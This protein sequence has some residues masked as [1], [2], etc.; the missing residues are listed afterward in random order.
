MNPSDS[1]NINSEFSNSTQYSNQD[2]NFSSLP[3][4]SSSATGGLSRPR[5]AKARKHSNP[6]NLK[7]NEDIWAGSGSG[8]NPFRRDTSRVELGGSGSTE[9]DS[10]SGGNEAFLSVASGSNVGF[11]SSS[12]KGIIEGLKSLRFGAGTNLNVNENYKSGFVFASDGYKS[13][14][15]DESMQKL[16]INDKKKVVDG[17]SKLSTNARFESGASVGSS[18][19]RNVGSALSALLEKKLNIEEAGDAT[20]GGG[21]S[22]AKDIKKF[23]LKSSE[24]CGDILA[25]SSENA[26]PDRIKKL[27]I[28]DF[29][30]TY[31]V[32]NK[33][34]ESFGSRERTGG[35]VGGENESILPTEFVFGGGMQGTD[36]GG[37]QVPIDQ[38]KVDAQPI[39]VARPSH[40]F[41]SSS[42]AGGDAFKVP[43]T[44][45]LEK[46]D[47][48]SFT[49]KQDSAGSPF[50]E[51][52]TPNPKGYIFTGSNSKMEFSTKVKDSKV[53]KKRGKL[54][55]PFTVPLWQGQ[56]FVD[57]EG[58]SQEIPEASESYSPMDISPYQETLSDARNSR[59]TSVAS[60][61]S[62]T[63]DYQHQSMDSQ[64]DV[65]NDAIDEDLVVKTQQMDIN[66]EDMKYREAKE[67]NSEYGFY[68][69]TGAENYLE[70]SISGAETESFK[71]AN[72]EIDAIN[73]VMVTSGESEASSSANVDSD[74]RT[75][76]FSAVSSEDAVSSGFTFAASSIAQA[77]PK[78]H[79]K[80][81]ILDKVDN[82]S[83]NSCANSKG[84]YASSSLQ[85]TPFSRSSPLSPVR[86][87][88]ASSSAASHVAGDTG[89]LHRGQEINQASVSAS[90]AAQ[91]ACDRWRLRGNQAYTSGDLS[92]AEDCYTKGVDCVSKTETNTSCL[93]TVKMAAAID[94]SFLRVQVRAANCY[95]ALGEVEEAVQ[96]F[97]RCLQ[98]GIDVCVDRK[99]AVEASDGLQKA[100]KVSEC[101]QRSAE[102]LKRG[103]PND[104]E[105]AL[106]VIS[107]GLLISSY[108]EEL[109][110][111]KAE[112]LFMLR[113]YEELIQLCE[114]TFDSAKKNSPPLH[115]DY[116]VEN[117]GPELK[118][119]TSFMIWRCRFVFKSYF[120][121]GKLEE[122]IA[123]LEKQEELTSI[124]RSSM[125]RND[126]ET[127]ASLV[128]LAAIVQELLRHKAAGNEA[129]QAG[130]HSEAIEHYSAAL[131]RNIESRPFAAICFCNRA[132]AY[133]ALGQITDA[134]ADCSLAIALDGNYLKAISRR[135]TLYEMIRDYGQAANDLQRVVA[136]LT[137]QAEEKI[138]QSGH[139]DRT[140]NLAN[141]LRQARL[142]LNTI[143]EE[144]RKEIPLNMYLILGIESSASASEVKKAYRKA[145]LRHHPDKAGQSLARSDSVDDGL[146]KEIGEEVHKDA[147]RLFKMIG[148]AYAMLSDPAKRSQYD[149]EEA[150]RNDPKKRSG[151]STYRTHT[152]AQNYPFESSNRRHWKESIRKSGDKSS[153]WPSSARSFYPK[154]L[155]MGNYTCYCLRTDNL[156]AEL[157][158][159]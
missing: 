120:H 78:R 79:H 10:G 128:P 40:A 3:S 39:G 71:S 28:K 91:E 104:A 9:F 47:G 44:G 58:G 143:E 1:V 107:E 60:E 108:S 13:F 119:G 144:A 118:K 77:S 93:R 50:V 110:E 55:Q 132:A 89:E 36:V 73:D 4:L 125:S 111:M 76:F 134:I 30:D 94:P 147:D 122:A 2:P 26:L 129:F 105:S 15:V 65:L 27:N 86:S 57:R 16:S 138:K 90:V 53:K 34:S 80:K 155:Q 149:F 54:K 66:E 41:S 95:L 61:E 83:F 72:E 109:L 136:V 145:A 127:Q 59:E 151:S 159:R 18:I 112:S 62:F 82:D 157:P 131:S 85:F 37:F 24:N 130:K 14:G 117:L 97:K 32:T 150:K 87:K 52:K 148:E 98:L 11:N 74:L 139:S 49:S 141:D 126:I 140:T 106:Q 100:Q 43:P 35:F 135:A 5:L 115:A 56:G 154:V 124:A 84:S 12:S 81:K 64:P 38:P 70:E 146:L 102:L 8:Y 137:K 25:D 63:L 31:N 69:D 158:N 29:V 153:G 121:L 22:G 19:G 21:S 48:F 99:I 6:R 114:H 20:N 88:K 45:G 133:K 101:M 92:Q 75:Q 96:Y 103:A 156:N 42:L 113:K 17:E 68:K 142:R 116:H 7:V 152:E 67:E 51:F 33:T 123:S 46:T 23:G